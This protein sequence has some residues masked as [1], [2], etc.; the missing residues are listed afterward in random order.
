MIADVTHVLPPFP[1]L[2]LGPVPLP[3]RINMD[4]IK[5]LQSLYRDHCEVG[6]HTH[7]HTHVSKCKPTPIHISNA[8]G[9]SPLV[10]SDMCQEML[11]VLFNGGLF[12]A[13]WRRLTLFTFGVYNAALFL[14]RQVHGFHVLN[15]LIQLFMALWVKKSDFLNFFPLS[16]RCH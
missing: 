13:H 8:K 9:Q 6:H 4:D 16:N 3:E 10:A 15:C 7:T 11:L 12:N 5:K 14:E 2:D 1:P